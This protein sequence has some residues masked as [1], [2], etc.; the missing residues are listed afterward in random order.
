MRLPSAGAFFSFRER[1]LTFVSKF[2]IDIPHF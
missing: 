1:F 2:S